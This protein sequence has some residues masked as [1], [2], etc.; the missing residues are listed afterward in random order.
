M[1]GLNGRYYQKNQIIST[2]QRVTRRYENISSNAQLVSS[3]LDKYRIRYIH[4][5]DYILEFVGMSRRDYSKAMKGLGMSTPMTMINAIAN[6]RY[7]W[8]DLKFPASLS[9]YFRIPSDLLID[10]DF[11]EEQV[12][13]MRFGLT[14]NCYKKRGSRIRSARGKFADPRPIS[15]ARICI[16]NNANNQASRPPRAFNAWEFVHRKESK[17]AICKR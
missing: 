12:D 8:F 1:E 7:L 6:G 9:S 13:L 14:R 2:E 15:I 3:I 17:D 11:L 5:L 4:N 16:V 10:K